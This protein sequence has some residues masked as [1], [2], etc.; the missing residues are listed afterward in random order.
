MK[1]LMRSLMLVAALALGAAAITAVPG[2]D[3]MTVPTATF[4]DKVA[5]AERGVQAVQVTAT[6]LLRA[7]KINVAQDQLIQK[8]VG[9]AHDGLVLAKTLTDPTQQAAQLEAATDIINTLK[10]Q[11]GAKS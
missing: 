10:K 5:L 3:T 4:N 1:T 7:G 11:T 6:A 9:L 8:Q 2:C